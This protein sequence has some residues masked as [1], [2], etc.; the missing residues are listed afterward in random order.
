MKI[1][2][3][4]IKEID[5]EWNNVLATGIHLNRT[6][7]ERIR[8]FMQK[9][10]LFEQPKILTSEKY[11]CIQCGKAFSG[12]SGL[13]VCLG[14]EDV[15]RSE[16]RMKFIILNIRKEVYKINYLSFHLMRIERYE[17][18]IPQISRKI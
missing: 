14:I 5:H 4:R 18:M 15:T 10:H 17:Q 8:A 6:S 13:I 3:I 16:L 12:K 11:K 2:Y 9:S 7:N 1:Q